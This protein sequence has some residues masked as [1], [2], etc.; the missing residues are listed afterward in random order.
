MSC[1]EGQRW[2]A[3]RQ[4][5]I[6]VVALGAVLVVLSFIDSRVLVTRIPMP[7]RV[8]SWIQTYVRLI[9]VC[10]LL[11]GIGG[12]YMH[13]ARLAQR[14]DQ[15]LAEHRRA[16]L[17]LAVM[18]IAYVAFYT[19]F[20]IHRHYVFNSAMLDLG[21][22]DQVVW[23]TSQGRPFEESIEGNNYL[24]DHF[25]PLMALLA[26][27]YRLYP[28]V[29]WLLIFQSVCLGLGGIP[30]FRLARRAFL[31]PLAGLAFALAYCLY[32]AVG[33]INRF[34]FHFEVV[35]IPL[36]LAAWDA[37]VTDKP[38]LASLWLGLA[39][40]GKEEIGLT[41][42][43]TGVVAA[44]SLKR[45]RFGIIWFFVGLTFSFTALFIL[46]PAFRG[47]PSDTLLRYGWL[48]QTSS[49]MLQRLVLDPG[50]VLS[51][52]QRLGW[53]YMVGQLFG[54]VAFL[55]LLQPLYWLMILPGFAYNLLSGFGAQ[56]T[57]YY[58][59]VAPI[60][61]GVF[62]GAIYGAAW[63][64][65]RLT[66][67]LHRYLPDLQAAS[68]GYLVLVFLITCSICAFVVDNPI[69]DR[70]VVPDAWKR[71]PNDAAV[72]EALTLIPSDAKVF[73]TNQYG[74]HLSHR[75]Y[76]GVYCCG[77]GGEHDLP[78]ADIA[79]FNLRDLRIPAPER[80][81]LMLQMCYQEGFGVTYV[82]DGVV[83]LQRGRGDR[84]AVLSLIQTWAP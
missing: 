29:Y 37:L 49:Q 58:Q 79:L 59:Y 4:I 71:M 1:E 36:L 30:V 16:E 41:V 57:A 2:G 72:R 32:P 69:L 6:A 13:R 24:G 50:Y 74:S 48:G 26:I 17:L 81:R 8:A 39:L 76:L 56:H 5:A 55:N 67:S 38:R 70:G 46:I 75:R 52:I 27:P 33:Y 43:M 15:W 65:R 35:V 64:T 25:Q 14:A 82:K 18:L 80:Y 61:P 11:V 68:Y 40:F 31:S 12:R 60:I 44:I 83:I 20:A 62:I 77:P 63:L 78:K 73:T 10:L 42:A 47:G 45:I 28:S 51:G 84:N 21:I 54:P 66:R 53:F 7:S 22:Q 9:G 19:G 23:N 34:D 3:G